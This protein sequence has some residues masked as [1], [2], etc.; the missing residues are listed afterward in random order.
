MTATDRRWE[1]TKEKTAEKASFA[2]RGEN[3]L[4]SEEQKKAPFGE[5]G[6]KIAPK[7]FHQFL[8]KCLLKESFYLKNL[9]HVT[10]HDYR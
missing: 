1:T 8:A 5:S 9:Q 2:K 3:L 6:E 10:W 7:L 4:F